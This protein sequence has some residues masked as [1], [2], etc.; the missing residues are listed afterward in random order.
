MTKKI[1]IKTNKVIPIILV[2]LISGFGHK[3]FSFPLYIN[4]SILL[5][6]L[7][8]SKIKIKYSWFL[9]I[10]LIGINL[11]F[12]RLLYIKTSPLSFS[13][14][15]EQSYLDYPGIN[16]SI[17]RYRHEGV[18]IP[19][20]LRKYFYSSYLIFFSQLTGIAKLLSPYF[21]IK[22][23]GFSGFSLLLIGIFNPQKK[24][25]LTYLW[26]FLIIITSSLRVLGDS[27]TAVYLTLPPLIYFFYKGVNSSLFKKYYFFWYLLLIF[28]FLLK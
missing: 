4:L 1:L 17:E 8:L 10:I 27:L 15:Y 13:F 21:W 19:Y 24:E 6:W 9:L 22:M 5:I 11:I 16:E 28:D 7:C 25:Y 18:F 3:F 12:N 26:F 14:D 20:S 2:I 23:I